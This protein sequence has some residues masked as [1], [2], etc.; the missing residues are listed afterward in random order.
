MLKDRAALV[1]GSSRGIG[2]A[3]AKLFAQNGAKVIL[4]GRAD[5]EQVNARLEELNNLYPNDHMAAVC[6]VADYAQLKELYGKIFSKYKG[7][8]VLV[9]NAGILDDALIGT[10]SQDNIDKT[11]DI[12]VKA[13]INN[14]Q[15]SVKLMTRRGKGS[16]INLTSII[17]RFGNSG[18]VVYGAS[19]SAVIGITMSA[20]KELAPQNIRVNAIAPGFIDTDMIKGLPKEKYNSILAS[21]KMKRIGKPEDIANTALYLASDMS[22]YVTG[23][24]I[25]VDGGM[26]I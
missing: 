22:E 3:I 12:N 10:I 5:E 9:N 20:A 25:G 24:V 19:K 21:V 16:I 18:Q 15:Y 11:L 23:Q 8:D 26:L 7:L 14:L 1:T 6:D 17:G 13:V 2:W 4:N